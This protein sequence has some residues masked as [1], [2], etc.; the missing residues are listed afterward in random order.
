[1]KKKTLIIAGICVGA[2]FTVGAA[3]GTKVT[4]ELKKQQI[5]YEGKIM[6]QEVLSYQNN[7]YV[8]L[9]SFG[10]L[11]DIPVDY[12]NGMI[13]LG[14]NTNGEIS[15][16]GKDI[17]DMSKKMNSIGMIFV[18]YDYD[19]YGIE[20]NIGN[21]YR[22]YLIL[23]ILNSPY[24]NNKEESFV[25]FPLNNQYKKFNAKFGIPKSTQDVNGERIIKIY[26]DDV[27]K[28]EEELKK[29]DMLKD[30]NIDITGA[31]KMRIEGLSRDESVKTSI[32]LFDGKFIK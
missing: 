3:T 10:N 21:K 30:I 14:G 28:Y 9:K 6:N 8:P 29:G 16:W 26:I 7:T 17:K 31:K 19:G 11:V 13:Y 27:L 15:Y 4:A 5:S 24:A 12:K 18:Q 20:D 2:S 32:G 1:M 25:E 22:N 23:N